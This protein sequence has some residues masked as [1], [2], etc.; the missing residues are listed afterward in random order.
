MELRFIKTVN[1]DDVVLFWQLA[2]CVHT[3]KDG[4]KG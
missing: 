4:E 2:L 3:Q 1:Q